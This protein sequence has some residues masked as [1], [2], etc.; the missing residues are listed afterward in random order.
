MAYGRNIFRDPAGNRPDYPWHINHSEEETFGKRRNVESTAPTAG[1][2]L[3]VQQGADSPMVIKVSGTILH[4][5][6]HR[7]MVE[8]M[9]LSRTQT[10]TFIDFAGDA[11]EVLL[12]AFEPTRHR[13]AL[14][15]RDPSIP[16]H[17]WRYTL[18]MQVLNFRSGAWVGTTP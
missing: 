18:E 1:V 15:P 16:L 12:T 8:W 11:Y 13:A 17:F 9:A 10:V 14:N 3:I 7:Q 5:A 2:G 4:A 6:Q